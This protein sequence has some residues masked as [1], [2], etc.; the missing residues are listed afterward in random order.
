MPPALTTDLA[1]THLWPFFLDDDS[2]FS[3]WRFPP[4][5]EVGRREQE[6]EEEEAWWK[7]PLR[8]FPLEHFA[9]LSSSLARGLVKWLAGVGVEEE[10]EGAY[11]QEPVVFS[12]TKRWTPHPSSSRTMMPMQPTVHSWKP[13]C[14]S[15]SL[16]LKDCLYRQLLVDRSSEMVVEDLAS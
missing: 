16:P 7:S 14:V 12:S 6:E 8:P 2:S 15:P 10:E 1:P 9:W 5:A 11:S 3:E 13:S 4:P